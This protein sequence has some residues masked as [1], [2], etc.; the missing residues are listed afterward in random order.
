MLSSAYSSN[1]SSEEPE[2][3]T[4]TANGPGSDFFS[5]IV[6]ELQEYYLHFHTL[7]RCKKFQI[8]CPT[9]RYSFSSS[10]LPFSPIFSA[11]SLSDAYCSIFLLNHDIGRIISIIYNKC[12]L[13][14]T[15]IHN[16]SLQ[17]FTVRITA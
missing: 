12:K 11:I 1:T 4:A 5:T 9:L 15:Y 14:Y 3:I 10:L 16:W 2:S 8:H 7:H 13:M 6:Q 17:P